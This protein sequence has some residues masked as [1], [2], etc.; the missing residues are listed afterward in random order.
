MNQDMNIVWKG[1]GCLTLFIMMVVGMVFGPG[2]GCGG[3]G[4]CDGTTFVNQSGETV[5]VSANSLSG[6]QFDSFTL[7]DGEERK[8]CGDDTNDIVGDYEWPDGETASEG[9][10]FSGGDFCIYLLSDRSVES[11]NCI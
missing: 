9:L 4:S 1:V 10:T 6:I 2:F 3:G 5:S 8:V 11:G 7:A